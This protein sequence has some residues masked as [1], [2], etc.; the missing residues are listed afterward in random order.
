M[1]KKY[2]KPE[3]EYT[4]LEVEDIVAD[5]P[6]MEGGYDSTMPDDWE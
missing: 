5:V 3:A 1:K 2:L 4:C 6:G